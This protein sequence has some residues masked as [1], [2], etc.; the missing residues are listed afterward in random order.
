[1]AASEQAFRIEIRRAAKLHDARGNL[2]GVALFVVCVL[3]KFGR[4]AFSMNSRSHE[5]MA[6][7]AQ[8]ANNLRRQSF[9]Q[10]LHDRL[11]IRPISFSD[12]ALFD[13]LARAFAQSLDVSQKWFLRHDVTPQL[14][15]GI[16]ERTILRLTESESKPQHRGRQN[17]GDP[18]TKSLLDN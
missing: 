7:V 6:L 14:S 9:V 1:M 11:S 3:Q 16:W 12:R 15:F 13:V 8:H 10:Q 5:I 17:T 18:K 2:I 4:D